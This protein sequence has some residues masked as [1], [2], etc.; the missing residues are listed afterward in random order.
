MEHI[1]LV[2]WINCLCLNEATLG[3]VVIG[4][5][6]SRRNDIAPMTD[7]LVLWQTS[8]K[9]SCQKHQP[10]PL[11]HFGFGLTFWQVDFIVSWLLGGRPFLLVPVTSS[12]VQTRQG[13][14][15]SGQVTLS[16]NPF[17][18][19]NGQPGKPYWRRRISTVD[20]LVLTSLD[21]LLFIL[22]ILFTFFTK[23]PTLMG[24]STVLSLPLQ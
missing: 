24:R 16:T 20:L 14:F 4:E 13:S 11:G 9:S 5:M 12:I 3:K 7:L 22:K 23:Q 10:K 18:I 15:S 8:A 19:M 21:Q 1:Y 6:A 17:E 2:K